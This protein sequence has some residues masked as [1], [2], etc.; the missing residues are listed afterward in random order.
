LGQV[1]GGA[2]IGIDSSEKFLVL[3]HALPFEINYKTFHESI[4]D[5]LNYIDFWKDEVT[6]F[7]TTLL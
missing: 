2:A 1:T 6:S 3:T 5:F 4:E 7:L